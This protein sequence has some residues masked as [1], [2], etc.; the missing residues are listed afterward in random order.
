MWDEVPERS[1]RTGLRI[2]VEFDV[3][4]EAPGKPGL[5]G[6]AVNLSTAGIFLRSPERI[7]TPSRVDLEFVIPKTFNSIH[8]QGE[9]VWSCPYRLGQWRLQGT[10]IRFVGLGEPYLS[11][12]REYALSKLYDED[13]VRSQGILNIL[14]DIRNLPPIW[15]LKA[16]H[17]LI[18][19][20]S[21]PLR[22]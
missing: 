22:N 16:Y 17:I 9:P 6:K 14:D 7:V 1:K 4:C 5:L 10:G 8:V 15:R 3:R 21:E 18:R 20:A 12:I 11:L 2:P 19:K 13:F